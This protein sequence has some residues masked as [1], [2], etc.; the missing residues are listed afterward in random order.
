MRG[1]VIDLKRSGILNGSEFVDCEII[2]MADPEKGEGNLSYVV[3]G[4]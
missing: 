3:V 2:I 4:H 1:A